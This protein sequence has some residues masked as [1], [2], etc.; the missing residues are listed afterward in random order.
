MATQPAT[1]L[2]RPDGRE[3]SE[4]QLKR[5][6]Q[7]S[8]SAGYGLQSASPSQLE[9][10]YLLCRRYRLDP[11]TDLTLYEGRPWLTIDGRVRLM[12]RHPEYRGYTCR[13]LTVA[14][15]EEWGYATDDVVIECTIRTSTWGEISAR[16]RVSR[17]EFEGKQARS[18]A[19]AKVHPVE[20]AEKRAIARAERAAFGQDGVLDEEEAEFQ[21]IEEKARDTPER[22]RELAAKHKQIF[23]GDE[24]EVVHNGNGTPINRAT[25]EV[26]EDD[27]RQSALKRNQEL[28][29]EAEDLG[30]P[31]LRTMKAR[32]DWSLDEI[33]GA[34]IE[35][36][37]RIRERNQELD[38]LAARDPDQPMI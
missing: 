18:N 32:P 4:E 8:R 7:L 6:L 30:A 17:A 1:A 35:L 9:V 13:P 19:V 37:R 20:M 25:G 27:E 28:C 38:D 36:S 24:E 14:E 26:L 16:G 3:L 22:M 11:L 15:K 34:N 12:R 23:D 31:V 10:I 2:A 29:K 33:N 21:L 5:R